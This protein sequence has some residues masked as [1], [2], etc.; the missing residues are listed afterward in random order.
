MKVKVKVTQSCIDE[1]VRGQGDSCPVAQ[2]VLEALG[3]EKTGVW[4][5]YGYIEIFELRLPTPPN[6]IQFIESFDRG[7]PVEPFEF[8]L[9]VD[10]TKISLV[11]LPEPDR[12]TAEQKKQVLDAK[13]WYVMLDGKIAYIAMSIEDC[14]LPKIQAQRVCWGEYQD[15]HDFVSAQECY[16]QHLI[17]DTPYEHF[18]T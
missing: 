15:M 2:A 18:G 3:L 11:H 7:D 8:E 10:D 17:Y 16:D 14:P 9:D 6:V 13:W 4:I 12:L 1:G 5:D